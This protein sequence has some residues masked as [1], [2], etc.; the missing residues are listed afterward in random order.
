MKIPSALIAKPAQRDQ[1]GGRP[2][3]AIGRQCASPS[4]TIKRKRQATRSRHHD[5][6]LTNQP[7][8]SLGCAPT[9]RAKRWLLGQACAWWRYRQ[10]QRVVN[11]LFAQTHGG[12]ARVSRTI[13]SLRMAATRETPGLHRYRRGRRVAAA[14]LRPGG[15]PEGWRVVLPP[16]RSREGRF[17]SGS[18]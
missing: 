9:A 1:D 6:N 13:S 4:G 8:Q 14:W 16:D 5:L 3:P 17:L 15:R 7:L 18:A 12:P 11:A 10:T 2:G